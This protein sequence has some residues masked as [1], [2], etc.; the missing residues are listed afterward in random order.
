M[1]NF[2]I[3]ALTG[4]GLIASAGFVFTWFPIAIKAKFRGTWRGAWLDTLDY[5]SLPCAIAILYCLSFYNLVMIGPAP[6][7]GVFSDIA[8]LLTLVIFDA[9]VWLRTL[10]FRREYLRDP[11]APVVALREEQASS[12]DNH[13]LEGT[14]DHSYDS[15]S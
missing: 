6:S 4:L 11:G 10:R 1:L 14:D 5:I 12:D 13:A 9:I 8:R 7:R 2:I 3:I 15:P